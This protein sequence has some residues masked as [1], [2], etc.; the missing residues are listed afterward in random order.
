MASVKR[1]DNDGG[2]GGKNVL[3]PQ[4]KRLSPAGFGELFLGVNHASGVAKTGRP[5][6]VLLHHL[7]RLLRAPVRVR[8][9]RAPRQ[10]QELRQMSLLCPVR[11][12]PPRLCRPQIRRTVPAGIDS[13]SGSGLTL[14]HASLRSIPDCHNVRPGPGGRCACRPGVSPAAIR[15]DGAGTAS[16]PCGAGR[17]AAASPIAPRRTRQAQRGAYRSFKNVA[18]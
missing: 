17:I 7:L 4:L 15:G 13:N 2:R 5:R 10:H 6:H 14:R 1:A 3:A 8:L 18:M 11:E 9:S 12:A 16:P